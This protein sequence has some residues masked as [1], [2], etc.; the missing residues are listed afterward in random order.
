LRRLGQVLGQPIDHPSAWYAEDMRQRQHE[1]VYTLTEQDVEE[2]EAATA[3]A[4]ATGKAVEVG[5]GWG[6]LWSF[7]LGCGIEWQAL[8]AVYGRR[9]APHA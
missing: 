2:L 7:Q 4:A 9:V 8:Q 6:V 5:W 1:W 3:D